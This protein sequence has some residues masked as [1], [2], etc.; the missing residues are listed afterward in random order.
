MLISAIISLDAWTVMVREV[1]TEENVKGKDFGDLA[2][3]MATGVTVFKP[4]LPCFALN[5]LINK[6]LNANKIIKRYT[7]VPPPLT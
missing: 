3:M 1:C 7:P 5:K 2:E 6:Y 4:I